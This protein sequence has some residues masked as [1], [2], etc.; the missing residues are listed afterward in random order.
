MSQ[1]IIK[2]KEVIK[3]QWSRLKLQLHIN[4][5]SNQSKQRKKNITRAKLSL[6]IV[7]GLIVIGLSIV[8]LVMLAP[9]ILATLTTGNSQKISSSISQSKELELPK[10]IIKPAPIIHEPMSYVELI[11]PSPNPS[12]SGSINIRET[13]CSENILGSSN[14]ATVGQII[15][16]PISQ[17]CFG[18]KWRWYKVK[19]P[20]GA[21]GW[22]VDNYFQKIEAIRKFSSGGVAL[23]YPFDWQ[24]SESKNS[25]GQLSQILF[26][27]LNSKLVINT[28]STSSII[29]TVE[30]NQPACI[31]QLKDI[32]EKKE[33][34]RVNY[35]YHEIGEKKE[36]INYYKYINKSQFFTRQ[37]LSFDTLYNKYLTKTRDSL[38][39]AETSKMPFVDLFDIQVCAT[40]ITPNYGEL[41]IDGA[42][43]PIY[44]D[45]EI[46]GDAPSNQIIEEADKIIASLKIN[47]QNSFGQSSESKPS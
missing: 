36:R 1:V 15:E 13:P 40:T 2:I 31:G 47:T 26:K 46:K 11:E 20:N 19:W 27:K 39:S 23:D 33:N 8:I 7:A 16:G 37:N 45:L 12:K 9:G 42:L 34:Y 14:W 6:L 28:V 30:N 5:Q 32:T 29:G 38:S 3:N 44:I 18:D 35:G 22:S 21:V 25:K 4:K 17:E 10:P 24:V 43:Q 41:A